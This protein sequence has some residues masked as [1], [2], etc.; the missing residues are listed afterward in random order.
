MNQNRIDFNEIFKE[1]K[2]PIIATI[3]IGLTTHMFAMTHTFLTYDSMWNIYSTQ[4]ML[5]LGRQFL[6][7]ACGISSFYTLPFIN[8]LLAIIYISLSVAVICKCF[9]ISDKLSILMIAGL[10]VT[11]PSVTNTIVYSFTVDGYMLAMF[12]AILSYYVAKKYKYGFL[13]SIVFL[14]ISLGIYQ[15]YMS[16]TI[17]LCIMGLI[18]DL[19]SGKE[20]KPL[21]KQG[22]KYLLMGIGSYIFYYLTLQVFLFFSGEALSGYQGNNNSL[23][24]SL[25]TLPIGLFAAFKS[26]ARF[27]IKAEVFTQNPIMTISY[28]LIILLCIY[29][30]IAGII[31]V[32]KDHLI[33]RIVA[34]IM[35]L[36]LIP[37]AISYIA[38]LSPDVY[39]HLIIRMSSV[40]LFLFPFIIS[41]DIK[42]NFSFKILIMASSVMIFCF[43]ISANI[44]Y[45]NMNE[46]YE[47]TYSIAT[48]I[49]DR[50]EQTP[51]YHTGDTVAILGGRPSY[52]NYPSTDITGKD[53]MGYCGVDGDYSTNCTIYFKEFFMHYL[54]VTIEATDS[55]AEAYLAQTEEYM[56]MEPFPS[57]K[58]IQQIDGVWVIRLND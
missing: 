55:E 7:F 8:C 19:L 45:F 56:L 5:T 16:F 12:L 44:V 34:I 10:M 54:G 17:M 14:G 6:S 53:L 50:L 35:L 32:R 43:I 39:Y 33:I 9:D 36:L 42:D 37:F 3:L 23:L 28:C 58:S 4:H 46:R 22:F 29:Y 25:S 1:A 13:L 26:S 15:A 47:K 21:I 52:R 31:R 2:Y 57:N 30:V 49:I 27:F 20:I 24:S 41:K 51:G 48:R 18:D 40:S 11:F 38:I